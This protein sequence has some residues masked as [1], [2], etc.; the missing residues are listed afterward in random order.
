MYYVLY[1]DLHGIVPKVQNQSIWHARQAKANVKSISNTIS[2]KIWKTPGQF[3][4]FENV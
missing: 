2:T 4:S 1:F 3:V